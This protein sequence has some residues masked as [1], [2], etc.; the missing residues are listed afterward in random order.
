MRHQHRFCQSTVTLDAQDNPDAVFIFNVGTTL[1]LALS[2]IKLIAVPARPMSIDPR[3]GSRHGLTVG[4][5][6]TCSPGTHYYWNQQQDR[7]PA[8]LNC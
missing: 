8:L 1:T 6:V 3:Y 2:E 4:W 5:L 7:G